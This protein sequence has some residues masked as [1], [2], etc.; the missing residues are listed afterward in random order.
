MKQLRGLY[1]LT[2][3]TF[4]TTFVQICLG[5]LYLLKYTF[6]YSIMNVDEAVHFFFV[7]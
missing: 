3:F 4:R 7:Q 6:S 2:F 1:A 5:I